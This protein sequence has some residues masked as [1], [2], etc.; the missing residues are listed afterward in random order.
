MTFASMLSSLPHVKSGKL[1][2][3]AVTSAKRSAAIPDLPTMAEAGVTGYRR[4]TWYAA[5]LPA[6]TP[7][8][9]VAKLSSAI[10]EV[11]QSPDIRKRLLID[12]AEPEG[13][14]PK[15]FHDFLLAEMATAR[16]I[17]RRAGVKPR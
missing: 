9:I 6:A 11:V 17:S 14:S 5:L 16:D 1:R 13:S 8:S 12:G 3:L 7:I 10:R 15:E 2:A 4:T